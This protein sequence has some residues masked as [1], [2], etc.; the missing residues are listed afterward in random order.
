MFVKRPVAVTALSFTAAFCIYAGTSAFSGVTLLIISS[1]VFAAALVCSFVLRGR[2]RLASRYIALAAAGIVAASVFASAVYEPSLTE[3]SYLEG[4]NTKIAG[5][6]GEELWSSKYRKCYSFDAESVG[7]EDVSFTAALITDKTLRPGETAEA[8]CT[9]S[10]AAASSSGSMAAYYR[11]KGITLAADCDYVLVT[12]KRDSLS[13]KIL[14][15]NGKLSEKLGSKMSSASGGIASAVL[16]G[17]RSGIT[18]PVRRDFSRIGISHLLAI[19]GMHVSFLALALGWI[20]KKIRLGR[21]AISAIT[22][23]TMIFYMFLTGLS[24]SVVRASLLCCA[25]ALIGMIGISYDGITMLSV[26][27]AGMIL[28][29]PCVSSDP[30]MVLSYTACIG[31][32]AA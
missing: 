5:E 11:S 24:P 22:V 16:L 20:L 4:T 14:E 25:A 27:G 30:A 28:V 26:C 10:D 13:V 6:V 17:D 21:K 19:S 1:V 2:R 32:F 7:G 23:I 31:C 9:F 29:D 18:D 3:Y 8:K 15:L 12:G